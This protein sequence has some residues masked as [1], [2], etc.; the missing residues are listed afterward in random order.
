MIRFILFFLLSQ[1]LAQAETLTRAYFA[2]KNQVQTWIYNESELLNPTDSRDPFGGGDPANDG[3]PSPP[4][5][6]KAPPFESPHF[7]AGD[8]LYD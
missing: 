4:A 5:P 8:T 6:L 3:I 2:G 1:T 7:R